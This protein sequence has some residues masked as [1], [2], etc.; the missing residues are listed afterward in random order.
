MDLISTPYRLEEKPKHIA[1]LMT[2]ENVSVVNIQLKKD[3][4]IAEH[5]SKREVIIIVR[6]GAVIFDV[7]GTEQLVTQDNV[8]H[9]SP[10]E[11]HSLR[12]TEDADLM[13]LQVMP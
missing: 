5:D 13:V 9:M 1:K 11:K 2:L 6:R 3:E 10:L 4:T 12:A 8:L 7:E